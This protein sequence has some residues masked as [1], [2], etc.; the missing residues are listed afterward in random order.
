VDASLGMKLTKDLELNLHSR[1]KGDPSR[2]TK[3]AAICLDA[4]ENTN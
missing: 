2:Y 1:E 3:N 4:K